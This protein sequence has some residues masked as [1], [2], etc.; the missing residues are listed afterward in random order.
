MARHGDYLYRRN[1]TFYARLRV[2]DPLHAAYGRPELRRSLDTTDYSRARLLVLEAVLSWKRDFLRVQTMLDARQVVAGSALLQGDGLMPLDSAARE[3]GLSVATMLRDAINRGVELRLTATGW[4]GADVPFEAL[5]W[6]HDGALLPGEVLRDHE[7]VQVVG[8]LF[9]RREAL[10]LVAGDTFEDC[11]FFRDA[12]R[13][14]AVVVAM[15][16]I[17]CPVGSLLISKADAESI[18]AGIAAQVTPTMLELSTAKSSRGPSETP[19][20]KHGAMRASEFFEKYLADKTWAKA[21]LYENRR[22]AKTFVELM[23]DPA[24]GDIDRSLV[25]DYRELLQTLPGDHYQVSRRFKTATL[26]DAIKVASDNALPLMPSG[27]ADVYIAKIGEAF[28]WGAR[29]GF[30]LENPAA[31]AIERKK[32]IV[33]DQDQRHPFTVETLSLIFSAEWFRTGRGEKTINGAYRDFQPHY[34]WLP[35]LAL[36]TGARLNEISQLRIADLGRTDAGTWFFDINEDPTDEGEGDKRLKNVNSQRK[37]PLHPE[38]VR[39]GL[40][41]YVKALTDAGYDRLFPELRH[42]PIK[43]YGKQAG[44]WFNERFMGLKLKVPRDGKQSFHSF[45]HTLI[46]ALNRLRPNI[47]EFTINQLSGHE[48]GETMS[49]KRYT[50]DEGPD[51]LREI[52]DRLSFD[53]PAVVPFCISEGLE[54][55]KDALI[56][57]D[58]AGRSFGRRK[59][60]V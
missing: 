45:R 11:L 50:E 54:A 46:T 9:L 47:P 35:L 10:S 33:R 29:K 16:G 7:P 2:P 43:G 31:G 59:V 53:I 3:C 58:R 42:D 40:P 4:Q 26:G 21:T 57:K 39:L 17:S 1:G 30:M 55:I 44:Q 56:R 23:N 19:K 49:T 13:K 25:H 38:L 32:K 36:Y 12:A 22:F 41:E 51:A 28:N 6:D 27:R 52:V 37:V 18:R 15:P 24:L 5:E 14:R 8:A 48:R 60:N 34:F 20:H